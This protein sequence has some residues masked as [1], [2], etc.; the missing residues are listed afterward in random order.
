MADKIPRTPEDRGYL[1]MLA[2]RFDWTYH[3]AGKPG[4][5]NRRII[6]ST[7]RDAMNLDETC[8]VLMQLTFLHRLEIPARQDGGN[9]WQFDMEDFF[10]SLKPTDEAKLPLK[11]KEF[12]RQHVLNY[13]AQAAMTDLTADL[14]MLSAYLKN[15]RIPY[16]FFAY[17]PLLETTDAEVLSN[18]LLNYSLNEDPWTL[19]TLNDSLTTRMG[20]GDWYYD[21]DGKR[22]EIGHFN[23]RGHRRAADILEDLLIDR[24]VAPRLATTN[25]IGDLL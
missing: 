12:V 24:Q 14:I 22:G 7:L 23:E 10:V 6:R 21:A 19:N 15:R 2:D 1:E 13:D 20:A 11:Q 5:C 25:I 4:S 8:L 16:F 17:Q 18:N 3:N 9:D